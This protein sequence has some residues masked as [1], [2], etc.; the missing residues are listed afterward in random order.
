LGSQPCEAT[1]FEVTKAMAAGDIDLLHFACHGEAQS[2]RIWEAG[3]LMTGSGGVGATPYARE[4]ISMDITQN[5]ARMRRADGGRAMVF[6]NACQA[7]RTGMTLTGNGGMARAFI[8]KGAGLFVGTLWSVGDNTALTF[9]RTF[10]ERLLQGER[11]VD[12]TRQARAAAKHAQEP[13][14]LAYTVYGHP[15]ARLS[16]ERGP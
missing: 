10:Y 15:Y 2:K 12:A 6:L 3:L 11:L 5:Y 9:A 14:W 13:T 16:V 7:G 1:L 8:E 4:V